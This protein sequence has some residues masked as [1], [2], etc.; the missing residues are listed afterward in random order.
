[1]S[2]DTNNA[3]PV[4]K[5]SIGGQALMEGIMMR[6]PKTTAMAVRNP[7]GEIVL[8]TF[9]TAGKQRPA[10]CRWPIIRGVIGFIDSMTFGYKCLMRSAEIAGLEEIE[11]EMEKE[12]AA[13]KAAKKA[14]KQGITE[15]PAEAQP[16][17]ET[18][19]EPATEAAETPAEEAEATEGAEP[20]AA[21][22]QKPAKKES[23]AMMTLVMVVSVILAVGIAVGLFILLP[24]FL[25]DHVLERYIPWFAD[26]AKWMQSIFEGVLRVLLL[27]GYMSLMLLMKDIRRTFK[28]HGA[29]HKTIFCYEHGKELTVEN[30]RKERRFHPRCGTSFLILMM[31]VSIVIGLFIPATLPTALRALCKLA[32]FPLVMGVGY[33]LIKICGKHDNFLT[34]IIAAPGLWFQRI[35]VLEPDDDMI[36]CAIVAM[37]EAIPEDGS[38]SM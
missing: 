6:G 8:E 23:S 10:I 27:L 2:K 9:P 19:A 7:K 36:E 1:M 5:T 17:E 13:K 16:V 38:D 4:K 32:V 33:E 24:A 26:N 18:P 29:E 14:K 34:R 35:T 28:F 21:P 30:I 31:L 20:V 12:K 25:Y 22:V 3:C 15:A 37:K 11:A